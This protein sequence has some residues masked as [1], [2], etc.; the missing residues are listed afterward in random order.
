ME[1]GRIERSTAPEA[2]NKVAA[3]WLLGHDSA[4]VG[5]VEPPFGSVDGLAACWHILPA[6]L[7]YAT[8]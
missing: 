6:C 8:N 7:V 3:P 2:P 4:R 5:Y 1:T